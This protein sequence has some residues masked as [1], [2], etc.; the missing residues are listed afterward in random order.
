MR[1]YIV[2]S[3][4]TMYLRTEIVNY[5]QKIRESSTLIHTTE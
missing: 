1:V 4:R 3:R 2:E 5:R